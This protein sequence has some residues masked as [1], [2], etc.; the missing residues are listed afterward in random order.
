MLEEWY[1]KRIVRIYIPYESFLLVLAI[2]YIVE[3]RQFSKN[4]ISCLLGVQRAHVGV[5]GADHTWFITVIL[6][7]YI[8]TPVIAWTEQ[9]IGKKS[10][11][12]LAI[13]FLLNAI[14]IEVVYTIGVHVCFYAIA[15]LM[16][17][18]YKKG[19]EN[20][21]GKIFLA[22]VVIPVALMIRIA[23]RRLCDGTINYCL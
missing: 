2:V 20:S 23:G 7:C 6:L 19:C 8:L 15:Y 1:K 12:F 18:K 13:P 4:W 22:A 3:N 11:L 5:W 14:S 9:R 16:G 10:I 21:N 17:Q